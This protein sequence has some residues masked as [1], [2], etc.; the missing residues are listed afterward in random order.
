M[1]SGPRS[2]GTVGRLRTE[3]PWLG[4][5]LALVALAA[6][7]P[8]MM[9]LE[10]TIAFLIISGFTE[11]TEGIHLEQ[12]VTA[13]IALLV[14]GLGC[15]AIA[16]VSNDLAAR[17][18][19]AAVTIAL[20]LGVTALADLRAERALYPHAS[21]LEIRIEEFDPPSGARRSRLWG[22]KS[23][24]S[25]DRAWTVPGTF[26]DVCPQAERAFR[27]WTGSDIGERGELFCHHRVVTVDEEIHLEVVDRPDEGDVEIAVS[28]NRSL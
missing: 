24:G 8:L 22:E 28:V 11:G 10:H 13:G 2:S 4:P 12:A 9:V 26:D 3:T 1:T 5:L 7:I 25:L 14:M 20:G 21:E 15:I 27:Q 18:A 23:S 16:V 17:A 19:V 6:W